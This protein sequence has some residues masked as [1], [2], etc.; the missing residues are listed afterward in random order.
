[1]ASSKNSSSSNEVVKL[2][3]EQARDLKGPYWCVQ[4]SPGYEGI[5]VGAPP[6]RFAGDLVEGAYFDEEFTLSLRLFQ[7]MFSDPR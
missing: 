5:L 7:I 6:L 4:E 2:I 1:M 3:L